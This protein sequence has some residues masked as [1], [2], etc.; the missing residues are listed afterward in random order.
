MW[1]TGVPPLR[2]AARSVLMFST[3]FCFAAC[4]GAPESFEA[5]S[6]ATTSRCMSSTINTVR[7]GSIASRSAIPH[8]SVHGRRAMPGDR[9]SQRMH[10]RRGADEE[11][12]PV[13]AAPGLVADV[14]GREDAAE[15]LAV[16]REDV[17]AARAGDPDV[18]CLVELLAVGDARLQAEALHL[19]DHVAAG[20]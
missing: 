4:S 13:R 5:P 11:R 15:E 9:R 20:Q 3:T 14:L 16:P 6:S 19:V 1:R 2:A 8:S 18:A 10:R 12:L 7:P 17:Q